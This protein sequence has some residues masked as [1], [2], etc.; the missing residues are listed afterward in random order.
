[1]NNLILRE[2]NVLA[3]RLRRQIGIVVINFDNFL[4]CSS[5]DLL[6]C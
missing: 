5:V 4:I 2:M 1:M 6:C 3:T